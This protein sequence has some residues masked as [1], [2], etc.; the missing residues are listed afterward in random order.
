MSF[1]QLKASIESLTAMVQGEKYELPTMAISSLNI[2]DVQS[3]LNLSF[4][5]NDTELHNQP[6]IEPWDLPEMHL[7]TVKEMK[8]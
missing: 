7:E 2:G 1:A 4:S 3:M 5:P 8:H 6:V